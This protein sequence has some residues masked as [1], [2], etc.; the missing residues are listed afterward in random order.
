M[1]GKCLRLVGMTDVEKWCPESLWLIA[2]VLIPA[3]PK[4]HQGGGRRRVDDRRM[5]AAILF[6]LGT[7]CAWEALPSSFGVTRSTAHRRFSEWTNAGFFAL[8]H[9]AMLDLLG[10]AGQIDWSRAAV[11]AMQVRAVK[12]G[13]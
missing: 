9:Q 1:A 4:R 8:L 13:I 10:Q 7:G 11:D 2:V 12:G 3:H 6:V 5:L